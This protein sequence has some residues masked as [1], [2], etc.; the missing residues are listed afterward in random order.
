[1]KTWKSFAGIEGAIYYYYGF[2]KNTMNDWLVAEHKKRFNAPPDFF[3]AGGF[4]AASSRSSRRSRR[5]AAPT[6]RS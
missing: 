5:P 4:A 2:P 1:M 6:P 3:T